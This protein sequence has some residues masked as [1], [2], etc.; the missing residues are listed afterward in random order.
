MDCLSCSFYIRCKHANRGLNFRCKMFAS[1]SGS[2]NLDTATANVQKNDTFD[3][4]SMFKKSIQTSRNAPA[5]SDINI[6]DR[7][8]WNPP[9][10]AE[11]CLDR[12]KGIDVK[13]FVRQLDMGIK[14]FGEWC[15]KCSD[16][17]WLY[18]KMK[19][20][21]SLDVYRERVQLLEYGVCPRCKRTKAD[22]VYKE[23]M[24]FYNEL[25]ACIG[26]RSGKSFSAGLL[27]AYVVALILKLQRPNEVYSV[28]SNNIFTISL[29]ALTFSQAQ[30]ILFLP[31]KQ[32][33]TDSPWF[34][35]YNAFL[36]HYQKNR[37]VYRIGEEEISYIHRNMSISPS[38]SDRRILRGST[39]LAA[40][41][42]EVGL[43]AN[44]QSE[45]VR[46]NPTE[47][48]KSL[49]N[50]LFTVRAA[51][52]NLLKQGYPNIP[53]GLMI[54]ISSPISARDK[55]MELYNSSLANGSRI[56]GIKAATWEW[57]PRISRQSLA[58]AE[59]ASPVEFLR[60]FGADP[61]LSQNP[62]I[63]SF[64]RVERCFSPKKGNAG[65]IQYFRNKM[66]D[67]K[68]TRYAKF[69]TLKKCS[70]PSV[71]ALDAGYS[72]NSFACAVGSVGDN[73]YQI[74][75][76]VEVQPMPGIPINYTKMVDEILLPIIRKRNVQMVFSD[77]WQNIKI[78][79][80][81]D[82]A[83]E[84]SIQQYSLKYNDLWL[85]RQMLYDNEITL[86]RLEK[87]YEEVISHDPDN[88]PYSFESNPVA[89]LA[90]QMVTVRDTGNAVIKGENL[91]DDILRAV[92]LCIIGMTS[93]EFNDI[94]DPEE[95]EEDYASNQQFLAVLK[96]LSSSGGVGAAKV[97]SSSD[98]RALAAIKRY[99]N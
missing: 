16:T 99:N 35:E 40:V 39:R 11:F 29:V 26:Q 51:A 87:P 68:Y 78:L 66:R 96:T 61:P 36:D 8:L 43:T 82:A 50:S 89:H 73:G 70:R 37:E 28:S 18:N 46:V 3:I 77:R 63:G 57:N 31:L 7:D 53:T 75:L 20:N 49:S 67:G 23:S 52:D 32:I 69:V 71:L 80:D 41:Y 27:T 91:T 55:I 13:P 94:I 92:F 2:F 79:H 42:D 76:V 98:G 60:D 85:I 72:S 10:F 44:V 45:K 12:N 74:D 83:E 81:I 84:V 95:E 19:V 34:K 6:D 86:P 14:L 54:N 38:G 93:D 64:V 22:L 17:D 90:L 21:S 25:A 15:I 4:E 58:S 97:H 5:S 88:Y 47:I 56:L 65:S 1:K 24:P 30:K 48:H 62:W 33:I 59:K 9:N